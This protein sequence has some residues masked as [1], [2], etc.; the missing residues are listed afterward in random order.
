MKLL[1]ILVLLTV[2]VMSFSSQG[3]DW[4]IKGEAPDL[5]I[6]S[7]SNSKINSPITYTSGG[8]GLINSYKVSE[9]I[10]LIVYF[11]GSAGTSYIVDIYNAVIFDHKNQEILGD[12]PWM[13]MGNQYEPMSTQP[14][15]DISENEITIRD[16]QT[17]MDKSIKLD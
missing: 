5:F 12:F 10:E 3:L 9:R 14:E 1:K 4:I 15:W 13:Y 17:G 6:E 16:S 8:I 2:T 7:K 11:S